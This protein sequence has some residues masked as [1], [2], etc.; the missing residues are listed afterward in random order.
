MVKKGERMKLVIGGHDYDIVEMRDQTKDGKDLLGLHDPKLNTISLDSDMANTRKHETLLHE[1]VH[2]ILMNAGFSDH[3][4]S[5]IDAISNGFLQLGVG[6]FVWKKAK[7][8]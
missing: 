3:D 5:L 2:V 6:E 1:I 8:S 4:E 7:S